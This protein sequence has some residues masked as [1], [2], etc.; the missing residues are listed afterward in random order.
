MASWTKWSSF[1]IPAVGYMTE[2]ELSDIF[3]RQHVGR[4]KRVDFIENSA[5]VRCAFVHF[6]FWNYNRDVRYIW[7]Q[8][9]KYGSYK[10][11]FS[12]SEYLILR[13]MRCDEIPET[14]MN[15]HQIAAKLLQQDV[16][17]EELEKRISQQDRLIVQ[18]RHQ[19]ITNREFNRDCDW[20]RSRDAD[21][22]KMVDSLVGPRY[23]E[24]DVMDSLNPVYVR[25]DDDSMSVEMN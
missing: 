20:V 8:I 1:Y 6:V 4:V 3:W 14:S 25:P 13:M 24:E 22:E 11:W 7:D 15:I 17:I 16:K 21:M 18:Q 2:R 9:Y 19:I 5:G 23:N 12:D 10:Y